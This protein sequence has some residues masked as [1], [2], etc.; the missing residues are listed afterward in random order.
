MYIKWLGGGGVKKTAFKILYKLFFKK[1]ELDIS[2]KKI[3]NKCQGGDAIM[4]LSVTGKIKGQK[5]VG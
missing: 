5:L 1:E 4:V 3:K 2:F